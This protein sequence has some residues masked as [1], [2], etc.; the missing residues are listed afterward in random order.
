MSRGGEIKI[1]PVL[2]VCLFVFLLYQGPRA[3]WQGLEDVDNVAWVAEN[4]LGG[5]RNFLVSEIFA[6]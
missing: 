1:V 5:V 4:F 2:F 3:P 6:E